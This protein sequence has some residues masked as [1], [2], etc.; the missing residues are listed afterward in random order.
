MAYQR[1]IAENRK[2]RHDYHIE[3]TYEAGIVLEGSEVK[4]AKLG[5][6]SIQDAFVRPKDGELY[7]YN[8]HIAPYDKTSVFKPDPKRP[9][10]L[11]LHRRE[12]D[13]II[14]KITMRGYTAIPLKVINK[15][16]WIKVIIALA[17]GKKKYEKK[18]AIKARDI[19][20][21]MRRGEY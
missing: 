16:G 9:R 17:K 12:I 3:E 21:A 8:M 15:R 18:E 7:I 20:R 11:L 4:S 6:V 5:R 14:G 10:K 19:E 13:R 2:A 1:V